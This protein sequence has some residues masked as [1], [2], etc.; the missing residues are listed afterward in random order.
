LEHLWWRYQSQVPTQSTGRGGFMALALDVLM[1]PPCSFTEGSVDK[2]VQE[3]L[4]RS[5]R[6]V[7]RA[8]QPPAKTP[9]ASPRSVLVIGA[10]D[11]ILQALARQHAHDGDR[12]VATA[13]PD[14]VAAV[15]SALGD[16]VA[17]APL[18]LTAMPR[19]EDLAALGDGALDLL[20]IGGLTGST[21]ILEPGGPEDFK[22]VRLSGRAAVALAVPPV[23]DA[24]V[25]EQSHRLALRKRA[26]IVLVTSPMAS[27]AKRRAAGGSSA[28]P[29]YAAIQALFEL[30]ARDLGGQGISVIAMHPG[31][32]QREDGTPNRHTLPADTAWVMRETILRLDER[33]HGH[34]VDLHGSLEPA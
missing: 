15:R 11:P 30:W 22:R 31:W 24:I 4:A 12:V 16:A 9:V 1:A 13:A 6:P 32:G 3:Y 21:G 23:L 7:L 5:H 10:E 29:A 18:A 25:Q 27:G 8:T 19:P 28:G 20:V 17:V 33:E 34:L 2:A 26:R 14:R